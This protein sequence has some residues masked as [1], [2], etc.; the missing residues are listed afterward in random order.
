MIRNVSPNSR[1]DTFHLLCIPESDSRRSALNYCDL[2]D[3]L[4]V[5]S[6]KLLISLMPMVESVR[7]FYA[8]PYSLLSRSS[9]W[10]QSD[11]RI[12]AAI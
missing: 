3:F 4:L 2:T 11:S 8:F 10:F 1:C 7:V 12:L 6:N 5:R 9:Q